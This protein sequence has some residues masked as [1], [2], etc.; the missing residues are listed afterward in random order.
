MSPRLVTSPSLPAPPVPRSDRFAGGDDPSVGPVV[1]VSLMSLRTP[2]P[3]SNA[4]ELLAGLV[5]GRSPIPRLQQQRAPGSRAR[6]AAD[7]SASRCQPTVKAPRLVAEHVRSPG[8]RQK[9]AS[10]EFERTGRP[11]ARSVGG[12]ARDLG[13]PCRAVSHP[14]II[15][16]IG[17]G[18]GT[19]RPAGALDGCGPD[20][21]DDSVWR[22]YALVS[23]RPCRRSGFCPFA[24][25]A[26]RARLMLTPLEKASAEPPGTSSAAIGFRR[27]DCLLPAR[28]PGDLLVVAGRGRPDE[29]DPGH[30]GAPCGELR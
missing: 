19:S 22:C 7:P 21:P 26:S 6:S 14:M 30:V 4:Q 23:R 13:S 16:A 25:D 27:V 11:A 2:V 29:D 15:A 1:C 10:V 8:D 28:A 20:S 12:S 18:G 5:S 3:A 9:V 24:A 17:R